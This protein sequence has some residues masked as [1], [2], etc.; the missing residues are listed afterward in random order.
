[1]IRNLRI[2]LLAAFVIVALSG[3]F[4]SGFNP[5]SYAGNYTGT[6]TLDNSKT[7]DVVL[8]FNGSGVATG[9]LT[10]TGAGTGDTSTFQFPAGVYP[11]N[12][13]VT[14]TKGAFEVQGMV[15]SDKPF[16]I[17]GSLPAV[18]QNST[19]TVFAG[20]DTHTGTLT[21]N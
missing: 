20:A 5:G 4:G 21:H 17:R 6:G 16:V 9:S 2:A 3:C 7:G 1:M 19:Y 18:G 15:A 12:G 11:L 8:D 10:V 14:S 13:S